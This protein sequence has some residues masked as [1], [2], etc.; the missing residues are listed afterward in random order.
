MV[1]VGWSC[2]LVEVREFC[3][4][5]YFV[6][7][8]RVGIFYCGGLRMVLVW[9]R[10]IFSFF[11][12]VLSVVSFFDFIRLEYVFCFLFR[13]SDLYLRLFLFLLRSF[14]LMVNYGWVFR[15]IFKVFF[16]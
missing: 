6:S 12:D 3:L 16:W 8:F 7:K 5:V 15:V 13:L 14:C 2:F 9:G 10:F 11:L 4:V 1:V